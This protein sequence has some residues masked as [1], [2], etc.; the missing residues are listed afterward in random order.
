MSKS[1]EKEIYDVNKD[2]DN[3]MNILINTQSSIVRPKLEAKIE[4]YESRRGVLQVQIEQSKLDVSE[5]TIDMAFSILKDP[6][7]IW[8]SGG[9]DEK[10]VFLQLVFRNTLP[11]NKK[12]ESFGTLSVS[13]LFLL[14]K[15]F[16]TPSVL[17]GGDDGIRTHV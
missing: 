2:I 7:D 11:V 8:Q 13:S 14:F 4:E 17:L 5:K 12:T 10:R 6:Y 16:S 3:M 1:I 9:I 15:E